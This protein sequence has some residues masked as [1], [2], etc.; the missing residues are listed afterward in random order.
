MH[1]GG[2]LSP[3]VACAT[4]RS[5]AVIWV[6]FLLRLSFVQSASAVVRLTYFTVFKCIGGE[7]NTFCFSILY[8]LCNLLLS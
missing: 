1:S 2:S 8:V 5:K 6:W 7:F 4:D 3:S